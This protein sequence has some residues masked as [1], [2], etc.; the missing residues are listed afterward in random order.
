MNKSDLATILEP[1]VKTFEELGVLY[2]V[3]GSVASSAY[4]IARATL[5]VDLVSNLQSH[6]VNLLVEKLKPVYFIDSEMILDAIKTRSS[7]NIIH[8]DSMMKI[9][10]FILIDKPY[11][12]KAFE[13]K[14]IDTLDDEA[15]SIKMYLCSPEDIILNKLEWYKA[16]N[17]VSE[18]QW[19]DVLGVIKVQGD[20]L[21]LEYI[22]LWAKELNVLDLLE[23]AL[24]EG[25]V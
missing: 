8:L 6:Q 19:L 25:S 24:S 2:Y 3:S 1:V 20:S 22:K 5:D 13:R 12:Q 14:R 9:D 17:Q 11:P 4:G 23:K 18:R 21:E 15:D 7:F 16:G 10:V